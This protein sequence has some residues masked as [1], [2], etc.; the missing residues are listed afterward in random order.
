MPFLD[1]FCLIQSAGGLVRGL[2]LGNSFFMSF[3][4]STCVRIPSRLYLAD[5]FDIVVKFFPFL[6]SSQPSLLRFYKH[7][8]L[9]VRKRK[10]I[11]Y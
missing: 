1:S 5:L 6:F 9:I 10:P 8:R 3:V 7:I 4:F 11:T 2:R